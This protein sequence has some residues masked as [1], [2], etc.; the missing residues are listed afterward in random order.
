MAS[1]HP[2][3]RHSHLS[4]RQTQIPSAQNIQGHQ[5][6]RHQGQDRARR[7]KPVRRP[8][9]SPGRHHRY[10]QHRGSGHG[11]HPR[12][13]R[14]RALVLAHRRIRYGHEIFRGSAGCKIQSEDQKRRAHPRRPDVRPRARTQGQVAR[15]TLR[16]LRRSGLLRH[17]QHGAVQRHLHAPRRE[18]AHPARSQRHSH[19]HP[20]RLSGALR[21]QGHIQGLHLARAFHGPVLHHRLHSDPVHQLRIPRRDHPRHPSRP[22]PPAA[23]SSARPS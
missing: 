18:P 21:H 23:D 5:A 8:R 4:D 15:S 1:H 14:S 22:R 20:H 17:R 13:S 16:H 19:H 9:H 3:S 12:R 11:H 7:R 6:L 10:R 2:A